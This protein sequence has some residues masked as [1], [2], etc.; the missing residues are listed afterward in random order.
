M[1]LYLLLESNN[2]TS[3]DVALI[4][5]KQRLSELPVQKLE[6]CFSEA[7]FGSLVEDHEGLKKV[8]ILLIEAGIDVYAWGLFENPESCLKSCCL[9]RY[10]CYQCSD[11][12]RFCKTHVLP[13]KEILIE[14]LTTCGYDADQILPNTSRSK[15][16]SSH[17]DYGPDCSFTSSDELESF[18]GGEVNSPVAQ[19]EVPY[20]LEEDDNPA[21]LSS[22]W[23]KNLNWSALEGDAAV[24]E[25]EIVGADMD[26]QSDLSAH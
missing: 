10:P 22:A 23:L 6:G 26:E 3:D 1:L 13:H 24:W 20:D 18:A 25:Q 15:R 17:N 2:W 14:A 8:L 5:H 12:R 21:S 11:H 4:L 9:R 7:M 16:P 19:S